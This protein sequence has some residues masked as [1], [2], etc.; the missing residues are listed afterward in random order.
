MCSDIPFQ[1]FRS[2]F[3]FTSFCSSFRWVS[4]GKGG[5]RGGRH[6]IVADVKSRRGPSLT[7]CQTLEVLVSDIRYQSSTLSDRLSC[8]TL[9]LLFFI[10]Q[11]IL[12][13]PF[14]FSFRLNPSTGFVTYEK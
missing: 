8:A 13:S 14:F 6:A 12:F 11:M 3:F 9:F 4:F 7:S 5:G 10:L 1:F 2:H